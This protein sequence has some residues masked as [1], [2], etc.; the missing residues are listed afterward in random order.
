MPGLNKK[1]KKMNIK[2]I[3]I[4][5]DIS[6]ISNKPE[7]ILFDVESGEIHAIRYTEH[8]HETHYSTSFNSY[9]MRILFLNLLI[10]ANVNQLGSRVAIFEWVNDRYQHIGIADTTQSTK[11]KVVELQRDKKLTE[12]LKY[13][14]TS[15]Q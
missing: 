3:G 13:D 14:R 5:N 7:N 10:E 6:I 11:G 8:P 1:M 4:T 15:I 12:I 9:E 2:H